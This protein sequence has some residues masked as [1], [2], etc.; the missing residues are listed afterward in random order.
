MKGTA[1]ITLKNLLSLSLQ[2]RLSIV[3]TI[4][5]SGQ[6]DPSNNCSIVANGEGTYPFNPDA[7]NKNY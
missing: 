3:A 5:Y 7:Q 2:D 1:S 4:L 6:T